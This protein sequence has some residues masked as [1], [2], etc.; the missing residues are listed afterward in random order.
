MGD[1]I[2]VLIPV[3]KE[4]EFVFS[5]CSI[6]RY[7]NDHMRCDGCYNEMGPDNPKGVFKVGDNAW[8]KLCNSC[9]KKQGL[10]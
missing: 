7:S 8:Y 5:E 3:L 9:L 6:E 4:V 10:T 2:K 1:K